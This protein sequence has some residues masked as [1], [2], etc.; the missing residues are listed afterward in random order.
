[1]TKSEYR[2]DRNS[3]MVELQTITTRQNRVRLRRPEGDLLRLASLN[4][5]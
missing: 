2:A 1:M 3:A 4:A 5:V